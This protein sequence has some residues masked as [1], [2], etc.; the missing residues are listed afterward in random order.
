LRV[1]AWL[2]SRRKIA[3][4]DSPAVARS[5]ISKR[6][7][8]GVSAGVVEDEAGCHLGARDVNR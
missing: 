7:A 8:C 6:G 2:L 4:P 3:L 5:S 1:T